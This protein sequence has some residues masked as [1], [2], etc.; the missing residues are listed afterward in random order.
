[1]AERTIDPQ[2]EAGPRSEPHGA[3]GDAPPVEPSRTGAVAGDGAR[4]SGPDGAPS[5]SET[6][7]E[8]DGDRAAHVCPV[9]FCPIGAAVNATGAVRPEAIDHLLAAGRELLL[10]ARAVVDT[11]SDEVDSAVADFRKIDIG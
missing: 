7:P 1:M 9:G 11:R 6:P 8:G 3:A 10:A 4:S 5:E 2:D